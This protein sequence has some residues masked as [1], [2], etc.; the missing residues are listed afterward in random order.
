MKYD[1]DDDCPEPGHWTR[2]RGTLLTG[3]M[4]ILCPMPASDTWSWCWTCPPPPSAFFCQQIWNKNVEF[5]WNGPG[6]YQCSILCWLRCAQIPFVIL[7]FY[8]SPLPDVSTWIFIFR[9]LLLLFDCVINHR[10]S[11]C[12][13]VRDSIWSR[14][15]RVIINGQGFVESPSNCVCGSGG[16]VTCW[17]CSY[18]GRS[19]NKIN[20]RYIVCLIFL[21]FLHQI[22]THL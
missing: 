15:F 14:V 12:I 5:F 4:K 13:T 2:W 20:I 6:S 7:A 11:V 10:A 19:D 18:G 22:L 3:C 1:D 17:F 16:P 9:C 21:K 8:I